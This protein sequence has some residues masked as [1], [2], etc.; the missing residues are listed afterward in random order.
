MIQ[1]TLGIT[2]FEA[3]S[4]Y[5]ILQYLYVNRNKID[6]FYSALFVNTESKEYYIENSGDED[7]NLYKLSDIM[8]T[9]D[10]LKELS[11]YDIEIIMDRDDP[12]YIKDFVHV[13]R[14]KIKCKAENINV[15]T[16]EQF[17]QYFIQY[18]T[19]NTFDYWG[20]DRYLDYKTYLEPMT[21]T[22]YKK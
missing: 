14:N 16:F 1:L 9:P 4:M 22:M 5:D 19:L 15:L 10:D 18:S 3:E 13:D 6:F 17:I 8:I 12:K 20:G 2:K 7:K 21:I 11:L